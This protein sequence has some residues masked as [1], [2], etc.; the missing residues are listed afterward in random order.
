MARS[1]GK[2]DFRIDLSGDKELLRMLKELPAVVERRIIR[3]AFRQAARRIR[4][5]A[6]ETAPVETGKLRS[7]IQ[8]RA[9]KKRIRNVVR[10]LV[11]TS[12]A[13][14]SLNQGDVFYAGFL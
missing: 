2:I 3:K 5:R 9:P 7:E 6:R 11:S 1:A 12:G 8:V 10:V 14:A 4:D 13:Y